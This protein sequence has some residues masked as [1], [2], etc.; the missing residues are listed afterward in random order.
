M[1]THTH[2][3]TQACNMH[4][5]QGLVLLTKGMLCYCESI[6]DRYIELHSQVKCPFSRSPWKVAPYRFFTFALSVDLTHA[7]GWDIH[8]MSVIKDTNYVCNQR[9]KPI[10]CVQYAHTQLVYI[11][12]IKKTCASTTNTCISTTCAPTN[13]IYLL[14][15]HTIYIISNK[16]LCFCVHTDCVYSQ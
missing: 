2:T 6:T 1:L 10:F 4:K 11:V 7:S 3:H 5:G 9:Y 16:D 14:H 13:N 15:I 8:T 12:S